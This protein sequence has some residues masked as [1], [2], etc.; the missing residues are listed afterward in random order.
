M[1]EYEVKPGDEDQSTDSARP[2]ILQLHGS[3]E[4]FGVV[5][6]YLSRIE[7]FS[8][9]E[10]G[11]CL[12]IIRHQLKNGHNFVAMRGQTVVGYA[13]WLLTTSVCRYLWQ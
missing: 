12:A 8:R 4:A 11:H 2:V 3:F 10:V 9:I 5:F 13:G 1:F 6:D 7:P